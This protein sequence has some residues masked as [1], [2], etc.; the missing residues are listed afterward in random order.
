MQQARQRL[1]TA[2]RAAVELVARGVLLTLL[3]VVVIIVAT[4]KYTD[5]AGAPG[6]ADHICPQWLEL[7]PMTKPDQDLRDAILD[8]QAEAALGGHDIGPFET[9]ENGYQAEC[10]CCGMT[11]W[12]A[13]TACGIACLRIL[14]RALKHTLRESLQERVEIVQKRVS[15]VEV[16]SLLCLHC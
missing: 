13:R 12:E 8:A 15:D 6:E 14:V 3:F 4:E 7:S 16:P 11:T 5:I 2:E 9:V 1:K 10:K